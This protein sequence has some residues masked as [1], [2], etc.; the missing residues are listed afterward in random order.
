M[1]RLAS[2]CLPLSLMV[3]LAVLAAEQDRPAVKY[4][5]YSSRVLILRAC[6]TYGDQVVAIATAKGIVVID[7][8]IAPSLTAEYRKIIEREFGRKDFAYVVNTHGHY[9]HTNGNQVFADATVVAHERALELMTDFD[10]NRTGTVARERGRVAGWKE[11]L[12][13]LDPQSEEAKRQLDSIMLYS[14]MA[15]DV[16]KK[17]LLTLPSITFNDRLTLDLGDVTLRLVYFGQGRHTGDDILIH[18]PEEKLVFS[19]DLFYYDSMWISHTPS[20][21]VDRWITA[22]NYVL[23]DPAAVQYVVDTHH[24]KMSR[25]FLDLFRDYLVALHNDLVEAKRQG[26]TYQAVEKQFAYDPR[27]KYLEKSGIDSKKLSREH[28][29]NV[30]YLWY[31]VSGTQSAAQVMES[32]LAA[33]GMQALAGKIREM[34]ATADDNYYFDEREINRLG[35][36]LLSQNRTKE[37][38]EI[39]RANVEAFPESWNVYDS[40]AE[41]CMTDNQKDLAVRYYR[42]SLELNPENNNAKEMLKR[43]E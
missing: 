30:R 10:R 38:I 36:Q 24:R 12:K 9:D 14:L 18:C 6:E 39:F 4:E 42:K 35:Y 32:T 21:E 22:L 13:A 37:A 25:E 8:G 5:R 19:G 7:T 28:Q 17:F 11:H 16:E 26:L 33:S 41:A 29:T 31:Q 1:K 15:D 34:R 3:P 2:L 20:F 27:F 40:L 43:M 23:Q